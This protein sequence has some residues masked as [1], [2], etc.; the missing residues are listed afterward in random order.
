MRARLLNL[1][2]RVSPLSLTI[3]LSELLN[4]SVRQDILFVSDI[5][6]EDVTNPGATPHR[7]LFCGL[8]QLGDHRLNLFLVHASSLAWHTKFI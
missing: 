8:G 2:D 5:S 7:H 3:A 1:A 6:L 4:F